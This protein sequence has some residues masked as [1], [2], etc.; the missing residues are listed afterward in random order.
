MKRVFEGAVQVCLRN[1]LDE[2]ERQGAGL[3][4]RLRLNDVPELAD[5]PWEYLYNPVLERFLILSANT[6]IVRYLELPQP[7]RP[8]TVKPPLRILVMIA[9]PA[10]L[11]QLDT[12]HEWATLKDALRSL[13]RR[14]L[15]VLQPLEHA[16][17]EGVQEQLQREAY[18]VFH[19]IG[20]GGF[21]EESQNGVLLL[22]DGAGQARAVGGQELGA[23]LHDCKSLRL[24]VLN[25]CEGARPSRTDPFGGTAQSLVQ[26]EIPAVVAMQFPISDQAAGV[27]TD[28]FY[29]ALAN[30]C[31]VDVAVA[32]ARRA[33][34]SSGGG[35]EWGT[36]VLYMR[37]SDGLIWEIWGTGGLA[38]SRN[39][40]RIGPLV[41]PTL[42]V[43]AGLL[44]LIAASIIVA[45]LYFVPA[46]MP[47]L[48]NIAVA[49]F[50]QLDANGQVHRSK[51]GQLLSRWVFD[52]LL[53][54]YKN[55]PQTFRASAWHDSLPISRKRVGVGVISGNSAEQRQKTAAALAD[56]INA[57]VVIYGNLDTDQG[58]I[59]FIPEFYVAQF[60]GQADEI[61][62][63]HQLGTPIEVET[64]IDITDPVTGLALNDQLAM[65][66]QVLVQFTVGLMYDLAGLPQRALDVFRRMETQLTGWEEDEGKE[67]LYLFIGR[68]E[69]LLKH[70]DEAA[71][72]YA[73]A[74]RINPNYARA[75]IGLGNIHYERAKKISPEALLESGVLAQAIAEY[76]RA[77]AIAPR[78]PG[79]FVEVRSHLALALPLRL[80]G[81]V[82]LVRGDLDAAETS[83]SEATAEVQKA[84]ALTG[85]GAGQEQYLAS[86]YLILGAALHQRAHIRLV[87][88]DIEDSKTQFQQAS[89]AYLQCVQYATPLPLKRGGDSETYLRRSE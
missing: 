2:A 14:R 52:S 41:L 22:E 44:L 16:T 31:P 27:F 33:M 62:G 34:Y 75:R 37:A 45:W 82:Q 84:I 11:P 64:P 51:D 7:V 25:V 9:S 36:P 88:G 81:E 5:L 50:G 89:A 63:E 87:R 59:G 58:T 86:A 10:G 42:P 6:P 72:A 12:E 26:Q 65:R 43:L 74:L 69:H 48:F 67:I 46:Q 17:L 30:N 1:S 60:S 4:I 21:D 77:I 3:R 76:R 70:D 35:V 80:R 66:T 39:I 55:L 18:H 23:I 53:E 15:I 49:E 61:V 73:E 19:F 32:E 78:S 71:K 85:K 83:L 47:G 29:T 54:E 20:H 57:Q 68:E 40:V 8:L 38:I 24:A 28:G 13:E 56:R 79:A